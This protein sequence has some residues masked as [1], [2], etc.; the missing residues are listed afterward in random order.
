MAAGGGRGTSEHDAHDRAFFAGLLVL[1]GLL[2]A[3][4]ALAHRQHLSHSSRPGDACPVTSHGGLIGF[5]ARTGA[6]RWTNVIPDQSHALIREETGEI[7]VV[8]ARD[9]PGP[10]GS[11]VI[12]RTIDPETG[13]VSSCDARASTVEPA[14]TN[15]LLTAETPLDP[16]LELG[17]ATI[18]PWGSGIRAT[19][20]AGTGIWGVEDARAEARVGD[21]L[22]ISTFDGDRP[23]T[24]RIDLRTGDERWSVDGRFIAMGGNGSSVLTGNPGDGGAVTGRDAATGEE[25]WSTR[26]AWPDPASEPWRSGIDLDRIVAFPAG[27]DGY[28][29]ALDTRTG[30]VVWEAEGGSPGRNWKHSAGG[31]VET[32]VLSPDGDTVVATVTAWIPEDFSD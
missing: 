25:R 24:A 16:P 15:Q 1:V 22:I 20:P 3:G 10:S 23:G 9:D 2:G 21:D 14:R 4:V 19:D 28:L 32:A 26:P 27:P 18:V 6:V 30:Q 12:E 11:V 13:A 7:E 29:V 5:D 8:T 17:G 31:A